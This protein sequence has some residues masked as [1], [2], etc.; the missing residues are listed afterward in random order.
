MRSSVWPGGTWPLSPWCATAQILAISGISS[1]GNTMSPS[2]S[3]S[4]VCCPSEVSIALKWSVIAGCSVCCACWRSPASGQSSSGTFGS[5]C[6]PA[7]LRSPRWGT[8]VGAG[9][10]GAKRRNC[11]AHLPSW[12]AV[13]V[14]AAG[15]VV[16]VRTGGRGAVLAS[17][18]RLALLTDAHSSPSMA[19][20]RCSC[21]WR[22]MKGM[23]SGGPPREWKS[24]KKL[25]FPGT[26]YIWKLLCAQSRHQRSR[27]SWLLRPMFGGRRRRTCT[28]VMFLWSPTATHGCLPRRREPCLW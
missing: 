19:S 7:R 5:S 3:T 2:A 18:V 12:Q 22:V 17:G 24:L 25:N 6:C 20:I 4:S 10:L 27:R 26:V 28:Y 1:A 15:L 8:S 11:V 21:S 23:P 13:E 16:R 9:A 14:V